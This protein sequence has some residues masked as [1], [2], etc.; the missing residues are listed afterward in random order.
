MLFEC[1]LL[2]NAALK[3]IRRAMRFHYCI[4]ACATALLLLKFENRTISFTTD[5]SLN[6]HTFMC[7]V[8][9][10]CPAMMPVM[11]FNSL[12]GMHDPIPDI[13]EEV[14]VPWERRF[15]DRFRHEH[16]VP[17]INDDGHDESVILPEEP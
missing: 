13:C 1:V 4:G 17:V 16:L 10:L 15:P 12:L 6:R 2:L 3:A 11:N 7:S 14:P 5:V 8:L 9:A